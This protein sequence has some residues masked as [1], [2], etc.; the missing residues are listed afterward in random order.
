[1]ATQDGEPTPRYLGMVKM[2]GSVPDSLGTGNLVTST[3]PVARGCSGP[4]PNFDVRELH[5]S[6]GSAD[7]FVCIRPEQVVHSQE[8]DLSER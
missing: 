5:F 2:K 4:S 3:T 1:M 7:L 6:Y 8:A